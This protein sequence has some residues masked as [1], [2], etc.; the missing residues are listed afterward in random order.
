[1][2][3]LFAAAVVASALL[4]SNAVLGCEYTCP[5]GTYSIVNNYYTTNV[6]NNYGT[7]NY[8]SNSGSGYQA[9]ENY[10]VN[11]ECDYVSDYCGLCGLTW[12]VCTCYDDDVVEEEDYYGESSGDYSGDWSCG[13]YSGCTYSSGVSDYC[14]NQGYQGRVMAHWANLRDA[15]GNI[16]GCVDAGASVEIIGECEDNPSRTLIYDYT[17]GCYG[18]VASVYLYGGSDYEYE[19]PTEWGAC[20]SS[21]YD[22][23]TPWAADNP[24]WIEANDCGYSYEEYDYNV[25][26][27]DDCAYQ[28]VETDYTECYDEVIYSEDDCGMYFLNDGVIANSNIEIKIDLS[29][30]VI[31]IYNGDEVL[32]S[33]SC[34]CDGLASGNYHYCADFAGYCGKFGSMI[35]EGCQI[36]V[37]G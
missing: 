10:V 7:M 12:D 31:N 9:V 15:C 21:V 1:M 2:K 36:C 29:N 33:G 18:T 35:P 11:T 8:Y 32:L 13:G 23:T 6:V 4:L 17:T 30:S 26:G 19:N 20:G 14:C 22:E 16:I 34:D 24:N 37:R 28:A 5:T 25:Y 3:K 27:Y